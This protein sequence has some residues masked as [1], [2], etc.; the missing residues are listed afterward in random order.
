M[1]SAEAAVCRCSSELV[2][3]HVFSCKNCETFENN[4]FYRTPL[5]AASGPVIAG[6]RFILGYIY[7]EHGHETVFNTSLWI[8]FFFFFS[9]FFSLKR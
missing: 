3:L 2:F 6:E 9:M 7:Y 1:G 8:F 4:V 5:M